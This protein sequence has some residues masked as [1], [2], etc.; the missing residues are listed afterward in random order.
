MVKESILVDTSIFID[1][2]RKVNKNTT[3]L[4]NLIQKYNLITSV[5]TK[6]ELSVGISNQSQQ[7]FWDDIFASLTILP[8]NEKEIDIA[9]EIIK[10]L[11]K[12]NK[13]IELPD[14]LIASTAISNDLKIATLN[15]KDFL[16]IPGIQLLD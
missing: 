3:K 2:Y 8:L 7:K 5:I 14:I 10:H 16:R 1:Y 11:R 6:L 4:I 13:L 15:I 9:S 12:Q